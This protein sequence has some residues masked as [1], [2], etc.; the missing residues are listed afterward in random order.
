MTDQQLPEWDNDPLERWE[1]TPSQKARA[2]DLW[3]AFTCDDPGFARLFGDFCNDILVEK[4]LPAKL[5]AILEH[6]RLSLI[7]CQGQA[8]TTARMDADVADA[9]GD[10]VREAIYRDDV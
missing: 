8:L 6:G 3:R 5:L 10:A 4:D 1:P 2:L 9:R 7:G